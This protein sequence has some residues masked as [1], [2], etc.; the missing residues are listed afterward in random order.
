MKKIIDG[1]LY[2]TDKA[3]LIFQEDKFRKRNLYFKTEKGNYFVVYS[4]KEI[5][6]ISEEEFKEIL[7][8]ADPDKYI[9]LFDNV[10]NA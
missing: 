6:P 4:G 5:R 10:D 1:L 8:E 7:G 9:E 2:D 3:E